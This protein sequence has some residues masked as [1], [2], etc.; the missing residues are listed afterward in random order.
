MNNVEHREP[1]VKFQATVTLGNV[2]SFIGM[3][4][5]VA[6]AY[7]H[8][9]DMQ[10]YQQEELTEVRSTEAKVV[11]SVSTIEQL[12]ASQTAT[13]VDLRERMQLDEQYKKTQ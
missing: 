3:V 13:M 6:T 11:E 12:L 7:T 8:I 9:R 2:V 4:I 1:I 10:D 5:F